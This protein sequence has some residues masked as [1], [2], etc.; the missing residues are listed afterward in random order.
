MLPLPYNRVIVSMRYLLRERLGT[1]PQQIY[2]KVIERL[3]I[4]DDLSLLEEC[5][6][7]AINTARQY[8]ELFVGMANA[9]FMLLLKADNPR[10]FI[11]Y[12][13]EHPTHHIMINWSRKKDEGKT[14]IITPLEDK[15]A[16]RLTFRLPTLLAKWIFESQKEFA[17][18]RKRA[19]AIKERFFSSISIYRREAGRDYLFR[20][21]FDPEYI[22]EVEE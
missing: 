10:N 9:P 22:F 19:L 3:N 18:T 8:G 15:N 20:L 2:E 4:P 14:W 11:S 21:L 5:L 6:S 12:A 7:S 17:E 1:I 13:R 16:Y